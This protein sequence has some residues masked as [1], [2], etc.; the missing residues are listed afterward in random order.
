MQ[1][2]ASGSA[3]LPVEAAEHAYPLRVTRYALRD[4]SGG[5]GEFCGGCGIVRDYR[6]LGDE[7]TVSLSA[8]RQHE[9]ARG[10]AGGGDGRR[11]R[12]IVSPGTP[13]EVEHWSGAQEVVLPRD[14]IFRVET[15]GGAGRGARHENHE[16]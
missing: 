13:E 12:F 4:G 10:V 11:G 16:E 7:V 6:V 2:L 8:E 15:P 9:P 3:N 14:S 5:D 1:A